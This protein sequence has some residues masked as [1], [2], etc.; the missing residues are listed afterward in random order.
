MQTSAT[1][2]RIRSEQ[3]EAAEWLLGKEFKYLEF[4]WQACAR[5]LIVQGFLRK[6]GPSLVAGPRFTRGAVP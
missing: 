4:E 6:D 5:S 1:V 3:Q 2:D